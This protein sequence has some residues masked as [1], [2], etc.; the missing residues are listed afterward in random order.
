VR[1]AVVD[2][3]FGKVVVVEVDEHVVDAEVERW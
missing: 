1:V 2:V 3:G